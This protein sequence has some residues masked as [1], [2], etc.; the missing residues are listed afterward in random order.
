MIKNSIVLILILTGIIFTNCQDAMNATDLKIQ[1]NLVFF[2][3]KDVEKAQRFYEEI[4]GFE[5][6]LDYGFASIHQV[7]SSSY[8]GLVD[9]TKGMH[10]TTEPKT[11]TLAVVTEEVSEWYDYLVGQ[12]VEM[13]HEFNPREGRPHIGFVALDPEGY[14][15]E[16]ETFTDH[17]ENAKLIPLLEKTTVLYSSED[18]ITS[19]P[20]GLGVQSSVFWLYYKDLEA[21]NSYYEDVFGFVQ[22]VEQAYSTVYDNGTGSYIGLVDESRGLHKFSEEKSVTVSFISDDIDSWYELL[23]GKG[24]EFRNE[25]SDSEDE[26]V[27]AFVAYDI[28]GYYIEFDRFLDDVRNAKIISLLKK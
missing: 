27:R 28:A 22:V 14:F 13:K 26:P 11:V 6:V 10:K 16:F 21:A 17:P 5:R 4:L 9:E 19:R 8:I 15:L 2:Y 7:S 3:Y 23:K 1:G 12:N 18:M 24:L 20:S 25:L